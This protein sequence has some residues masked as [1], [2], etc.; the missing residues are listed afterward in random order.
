MRA[1]LRISSLVAVAVG[2]LSIVEVVADANAQWPQWGGPGRNFTVSDARGLADSWPEDGPPRLWRR[3]LGVGYSGI[4][5]DDGVLYTMYRK[6]RASSQERVLALDATTGKPIWEHKNRAPI[7]E[8]PDERWGGQGPNSTPLIVG[9]L[10]YTVGSLAVLHCFDKKTGD[11]LWSHDLKKEYGATMSG[12][13]GYCP[14]PIAYGNTIIV[15]IVHQG[16]NNTE[17]R[18]SNLSTEPTL[19][20]FDQKTGELVWKGLGFRSEFTSP[21]VINFAG[22]DQLILGTTEGLISANPESGELLWHHA[23]PA[24]IQT[25]AWDEKDLLFYSSTPEL[26]GIAV[27][28]SH[29]EGR[30]VPSQ[31]WA[32][33]E[34][35]A[36]IAT[37]VRCAD[38]LYTC[39]RQMMLCVDWKTGERVWAERGYPNAW[40]L[41]AGGRLIILD[42]NGQ[43]TLATAAPEGLTVHGQYQATERY[44]LTAPILVGT[45]LYV[46]DRK[47]IMALDLGPAPTS[48]ARK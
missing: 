1:R 11:V 28:L 47:F 23:A 38:H 9:D 43:L 21:T 17:D 2:T 36:D 3:R 29:Q 33:R 45:T 24:N 12:S 48:I 30:T 39:D 22:R 14:S 15:V 13:C 44:S 6:G 41:R 46:R 35:A 18:P 8:P 42:E 31:L 27:R 19:A 16:T 10:L 4:V 40:C 20:A 7:P 26:G 25:P 34:T 32:N 37:P 5:Y